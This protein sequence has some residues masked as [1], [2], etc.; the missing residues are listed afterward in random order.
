MCSGALKPSKALTTVQPIWWGRH[1]GLVRVLITNMCL[2]LTASE[3]PVTGAAGWTALTYKPHDKLK[4]Y[5]QHLGWQGHEG[6]LGGV[7]LEITSPNSSLACPTIVYCL[8]RLIN[9]P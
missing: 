8:S 4:S 7:Q 3:R 9:G 2:C 6:S 5:D 1:T